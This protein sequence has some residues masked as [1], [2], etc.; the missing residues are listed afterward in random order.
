MISHTKT[1]MS[2]LSVYLSTKLLSGITSQWEVKEKQHKDEDFVMI[3]RVFLFNTLSFISKRHWVPFKRQDWI[4][5]NPATSERSQIFS[6]CQCNTAWSS[7]RI[8]PMIEKY[9]LVFICN[10]F[11][12]FLL[13][14]WTQIYSAKHSG[15]AESF[16]KLR[17]AISY[18]SQSIRYH[19]K[20]GFG[21]GAGRRNG[22][23]T[24][25]PPVFSLAGHQPG[26]YFSIII[27]SCF[28]SDTAPFRN[29][30]SSME[31]CLTHKR[32][33]GCQLRVDM[34][35]ISGRTINL[36]SELIHRTATFAFEL[37]TCLFA[38]H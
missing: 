7:A 8:H 34:L 1:F 32:Q 24:I 9:I 3:L 35:M 33:S 10:S 15:S 27:C 19:L 30:I 16:M 11:L 12:C 20:R 37:I 2:R 23:T 22:I 21:D 6:I 14:Q 28:C 31:V 36:R 25:D 13:T 29:I 5:P 18:P 4:H 38:I 17:H 26:N